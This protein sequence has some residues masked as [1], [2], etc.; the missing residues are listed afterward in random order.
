MKRNALIELFWHIHPRLYRLS[1]GRIGGTIK[2]LP[3]LLLTTRGRRTGLLRTKA[4]MYLPYGKDFV[5]FASNL[6]QPEYPLWWLNLQADPEA[7]VEVCSAQ[8]NVHARQAE[9]DE[10]ER[11]WQA[12]AAKVPDYDLYQTRTSRRIPVVVLDRKDL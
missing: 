9:G 7:W 8:Y 11:L 2:G 3:V 10:R 4:L 12:V 1:A 5:V 6:G